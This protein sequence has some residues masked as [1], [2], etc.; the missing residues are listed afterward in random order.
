[1]KF[2]LVPENNSLSHV[3]KCLALEDGLTALGHEAL[4]AVS[5]ASARF[6]RGLGRHCAILPDLQENDQAGFPTVD[7]FS[8]PE[9]IAGCIRAEVA[10]MKQY[11]PDRVLGV[12]RFTTKASAELAGIPFDSLTCGC[13]L[14]ATGEIL[15]FADGEPGA[16]EQ[17]QYLDIFY[18]YAG[19]KVGKA[20]KTLGLP[21]ISDI[22]EMLQGER[23]FLWDFPEFAPV[24]ADPSVLHVGP[25]AWNQWPH[26]EVDLS[27]LLQG[28]GPLAV[29]SFGTCVHS[30]TVA[31]RTV[32]MLVELGYRVLLAAGGQQELLLAVKDH[33]RVTVCRF[34][35]LHLL[36]PH[37]A[38][39]VCHGGQMTAFEALSQQV[40]VLVMPLQPEQAHNGVCLE[41]MGC[42]R[43][44]VSPQPFRGSSQVYIDSF[45]AMTDQVFANTVQDFTREVAGSGRL[46]EVQTIIGRFDAVQ[47]I[48]SHLG[49]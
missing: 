40:P 44:M 25:L 5:Q 41:R 26:D 10:L 9:R 21:G 48:C 47:T 27:G 28:S 22:R 3:A 20:L 29:V 13:M 36:F 31:T 8:K 17:G 11:R 6:V 7:W 45:Q 24:S 2:L 49:A 23:T 14:H 37:T 1:M 34:A 16:A 38:L 43:R 19:A 4:V 39:L 32:R 42:G 33:P 12:F 15:G 35:P 46:A 30:L 18:R